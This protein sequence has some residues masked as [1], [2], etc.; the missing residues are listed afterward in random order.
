[1]FWSIFGIG[2]AFYASPGPINVETV[3][4]GVNGG[5]WPAFFVQLGAIGAHLVLGV[6]VLLGLAPLIKRP[7]A[8]LMLH[9][10]SASV[11]L[12][13]AWAAVHDTQR[14][15]LP[16][17]VRD[18]VFNSL[19]AG[20]L[21]A[22]SN[23]L[24]GMVWITV[25]DVA[26][27]YGFTDLRISDVALITFGYLIGTLTWAVAFAAC[28]GRGQRLLQSRAWRWWNVASGAALAAYAVYSLW[29]TI[30]GFH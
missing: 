26:A 5:P 14:A 9:V 19:M 20:A 29:Q 28:I 6:A 2:L 17:P 23:P 15:L 7:E 12:W 1:M 24:T 27:A 21:C 16:L 30:Q 3:R 18:S 4:R 25:V 11:L 13:L 22:A 10:F 8:Q